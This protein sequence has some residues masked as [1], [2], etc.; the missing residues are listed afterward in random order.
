M[1]NSLWSAALIAALQ[2][3]ST[4]QG[5]GVSLEFN[6]NI[7]GPSAGGVLCLGIMSALE[8]RDF[9]NDFAMTGTILPDGTIGLVGGVPEK[10][11]AAAKNPR[12]K[13]VAVPAFER[14]VR[15][16]KGNWVDIF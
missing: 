12:I 3:D 1:R 8:G 13:R 7:D 11:L 5:V 15:D 14:F 4:L 9:P 6:G 16:E 10:L 2:T